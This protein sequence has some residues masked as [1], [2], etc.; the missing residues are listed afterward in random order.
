M[1]GAAI[2]GWWLGSVARRGVRCV[3]LVVLAWAVTGC[4]WTQIGSGPGRAYDDRFEPT[5]TA[6]NVGGLTELWSAPMAGPPII[7]QGAVYAIEGSGGAAA[8]TARDVRTGAV[9]WT[10]L[11]PVDRTNAPAYHGGFVYVAG[12]DVTASCPPEGGFCTFTQSNSALFS[13]DA[14]TG[15]P[16]RVAPMSTVFAGESALTRTEAIVPG[17]LPSPRDPAPITMENLWIHSWLGTPADRVLAVPVAP[18]GTAPVIDAA[19][20]LLITQTS[21]TPGVEALSLDCTDPCTP[22]WTHPTNGPPALRASTSAAVVV[23]ASTFTA[24]QNVE[25]LDPSSG[26]LLYAGEALRP[27][28]VAARGTR[29]WVVDDEEQLAMYADCGHD[30]C[31]PVWRAHS[32]TNGHPVLGGD[33]VYVRGR[34]VEGVVDL[35]A[36]RADG[37]GQNMCEPLVRVPLP[38]AA[39]PPVV[40]SGII[41]VTGDDAETHILGI[42]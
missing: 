33:L 20:R 38:A 10:R 11:L 12:F 31:P 27:N 16:G 14:R 13:F 21:I 25:V 7:A 15:E 29:V 30:L 2:D 9:R 5:L 26:A 32:F 39:S 24:T 3:L 34:T 23:L 42:P 4:W 1:S 28:E 37:C 22:A 41:A 18:A 8:L 6:R 17:G 35:E 40:G 36:Y 19:R